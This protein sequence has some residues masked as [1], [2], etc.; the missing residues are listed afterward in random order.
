MPARLL[1]GLLALLYPLLVYAGLQYFPLAWVSF[2]L[3]A[4]ILLRVIWLYRQPIA[5][6]PLQQAMKPALL[7]ALVCTALSSLLN[8][9]GALTLVPVVINATCLLA[10]G[11]T[12]RHPPSMIERF[13]RLYEGELDARAIAYTRRV[14][15]VWCVF[16]I[17]NGSVALY[18]ALFCSLHIW[19]LYNGL[20]AYILMGLLFAGEYLIRQRVKA[21]PHS[22]T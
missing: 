15:Q 18:T 6:S 22:P 2:A 3:A 4:L 17:L 9:A 12:L 8:N 5:S 16:F 20:I 13:A 1:I 10:F 7:L 21:R 19:T 11:V 14:T